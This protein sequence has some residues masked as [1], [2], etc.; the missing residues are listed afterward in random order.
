MRPTWVFT[1][2]SARRLGQ[3]GDTLVEHV[4]DPV[5][6]WSS[7]LLLA[8][9]Q[10]SRAGWVPVVSFWAGTADL[11]ASLDQPPGHGHRY[12]AE[13]VTALAQVVPSGLG[14][15]RLDAVRVAVTDGG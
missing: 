1:V 10:R 11:L 12:G 4:D 3:P 9:T 5:T 15:E 7:Q 13:L 2:C 8:P 6:A 14:T